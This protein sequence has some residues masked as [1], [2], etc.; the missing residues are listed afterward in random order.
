[1]IGLP[2]CASPLRRTEACLPMIITTSSRWTRLSRVGP[3]PGV[4][5]CVSRRDN[6]CRNPQNG[7]ECSHRIEP[8]IEAEYIFIEVGLQMLWFNTTMM[9]SFDPGFQVA[10]NKV[11]HRQ[12]RF[13]LIWIAIECQY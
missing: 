5:L 1:M 12:M 10:E 6:P 13:C 4:K 3:F 11:N 7:V 2:V 9:R 8:S